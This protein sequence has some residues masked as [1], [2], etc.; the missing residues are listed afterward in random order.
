MRPLDLETFKPLSSKPLNLVEPFKPSNVQA[1]K[2]FKLLK[3]S[4]L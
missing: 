2:P 4:N 3:T 1:F